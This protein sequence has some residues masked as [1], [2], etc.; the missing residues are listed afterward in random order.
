[1]SLASLALLFFQVGASL[2]FVATNNAA[3]RCPQKSMV[4]GITAGDAAD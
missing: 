1:M 3:A 2:R 4:P